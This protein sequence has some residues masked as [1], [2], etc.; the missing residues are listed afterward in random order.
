[1]DPLTTASH[2]MMAAQSAFEASADRIASMG[3]NPEVDPVVELV[4]QIGARQA[5]AA[6]VAVVRFSDQMWRSLLE[7]QVR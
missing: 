6:N 2:G 7:L 4:A 5:F 3:D 1:M